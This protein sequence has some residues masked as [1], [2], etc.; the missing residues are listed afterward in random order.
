LGAKTSKGYGQIH[1]HGMT[2]YAHHVAYE[3]L[4]GSIPE[5]LQVL[6]HCDNPSC[7]NP[8]HLFLGTARDNTHDMMAK[9]RLLVGEHRPERDGNAKLTREQVLRIRERYSRDR[10]ARAQ[11]AQEFGISATHVWAIIHR[12]VWKDT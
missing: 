12:K 9:G 5:G 7:V 4:V 6:H 8:E 3:L 10:M 1:R 11:L 2:A